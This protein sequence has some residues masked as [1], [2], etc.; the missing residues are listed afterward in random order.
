ML[1]FYGLP[2]RVRLEG[3]Q[4]AWTNQGGATVLDITQT[5]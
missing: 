4:L 3:S 2:N 5:Q 1:A